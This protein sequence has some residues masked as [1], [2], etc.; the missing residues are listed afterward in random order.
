MN[1]LLSYQQMAQTL[2]NIKTLSRKKK[3]QEERES[4]RPSLSPTKENHSKQTKQK[5]NEVPLIYL[6]LSILSRSLHYVGGWE[7]MRKILL[8]MENNLQVVF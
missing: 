5:R 6:F 4:V 2:S 7:L 1:L 8:I 3:K